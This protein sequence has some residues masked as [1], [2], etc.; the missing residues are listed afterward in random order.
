[1]MLRIL[2]DANTRQY[3]GAHE[4][5][6]P[7]DFNGKKDGGDDDDDEEVDDAAM[8]PADSHSPPEHA[9]I[10][11]LHN[12][13]PY[14]HIRHATP[15]ASP[16][17][18]N[19]ML[20]FHPQ[21]VASPQP[22]NISRPASRAAQAHVRRTSSN[23]L[24]PQAHMGVSQPGPPQNSYAYMPNP[25]IYNPQAAA[26][27]Q[28][29]PGQPVQGAQQGQPQQGQPQPPYGYAQPIPNPH[30][31]QAYQEE[32][33]RQSMPRP[34]STGPIPSPPQI[35]QQ[36]PP[37]QPAYSASPPMPQPRPLSVNAKSHS[38]FTPIDDSRSLLAQWGAPNDPPRTEPAVKIEQQNPR[39]Q[40][41]DTA[42]IHR[43]HINGRPSPNPRVDIQGPTRTASASA[44]PIIQPPSRTNSMPNDP[45]RPKLKVQIPSEHSD[46]EATGSSPAGAAA[47]A[48]AA[49][50]PVGRDGHAG[51]VLPPPSP[52]ASALLSAGASGPP[53]P[54]ARPAPPSSFGNR[55]DNQETPI[56]ALPSRFVADQLLP[57]PS[58]FYP[59]WGFG[60]DPGMLPSPL[61]FPTPTVTGGIAGLGGLDDG[62][63]KRKT[64]EGEDAGMGKRIKT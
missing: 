17:M 5:K 31:Q 58:S 53:N 21:R 33:R 44:V 19:G 57:S 42:A 28:A 20:G 25:P 45:K 23:L 49:M 47:D 7:E 10:P 1:M 61:A 54:F 6:G 27:V 52:S 12:Q 56:S 43:D 4:H 18:P 62:E 35:I 22:G 2:A 48:N 15:S 26:G 3:G 32:Q 29:R 8:N 13:P 51:V 38:I 37:E 50:T 41:I 40:S 63:R 30:V 59:D 16:P 55:S 60:R 14:Q 46:D 9:M 39:S 24:A 34:A 36:P 64:S 11:Q